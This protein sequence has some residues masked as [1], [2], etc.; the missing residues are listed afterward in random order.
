MELQ[1]DAKQ[2]LQQALADAKPGE[3]IDEAILRACKTLH[4]GQHSEVFTAVSRMIDA[5][6]QGQGVPKDEAIRQLASSPGAATI[7]MH[8]ST[9]TTTSTATDGDL[10]SLDDLPPEI[11]AKL[12]EARATGGGRVVIERK[13]VGK[14]QGT[15]APT[16]LCKRCGYTETGHFGRCP[17]CGTRPRGGLLGW[18]FGR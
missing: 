7:S 16:F 9:V 13:V 5:M 8:S 12:R 17:H 1:I 14:P 4:A 2:V 10:D 18:L 6:A 11:Q 15:P 3:D